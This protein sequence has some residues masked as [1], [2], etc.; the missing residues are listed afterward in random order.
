MRISMT[1]RCE[2]SEH[3]AS[4]DFSLPPRPRPPLSRARALALSRT[5]R[6]TAG[7][8]TGGRERFGRGRSTPRAGALPAA[9]RARRHT[10]AEARLV[11]RGPFGE[12]LQRRHR[13]NTRPCLDALATT[14]QHR[15]HARK[16]RIKQ[17]WPVRFCAGTQ[18]GREHPRRPSTGLPSKVPGV[19]RQ[20]WHS[21]VSTSLGSPRL[22]GC[23]QPSRAPSLSLSH[24]QDTHMPSH[25]TLCS[26]DT[27]AGDSPPEPAAPHQTHSSLSTTAQHHSHSGP[28][29]R[30]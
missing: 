13:A 23:R 18:A 8:S 5:H 15:Q 29:E 27:G 4:F 7:A 12:C 10:P 24:T 20:T 14:A 6:P 19:K 9:L 26:P 16:E 17:E 1:S 25:P 21:A 3:T 22:T 28:L 2:S 11:E 30:L